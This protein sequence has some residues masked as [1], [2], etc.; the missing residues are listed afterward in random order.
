MTASN[1]NVTALNYRL[2]FCT[3]FFI[4]PYSVCVTRNFYRNYLRDDFFLLAF[5]LSPYLKLKQALVRM[6]VKIKCY[7]VLEVI[8]KFAFCQVEN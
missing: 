4:H 2:N 8:L 7:L 5:V 1:H 3:I 6:A